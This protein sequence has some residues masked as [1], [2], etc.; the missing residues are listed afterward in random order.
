MSTQ[1]IPLAVLVRAVA[2]LEA[3]HEADV[4]QRLTLP[5]DLYMTVLRAK[6]DLGRLLDPLLAQQ[7][8]VAS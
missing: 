8:E 2:A 7:V 6:S 4:T 3:V 5:A 1:A